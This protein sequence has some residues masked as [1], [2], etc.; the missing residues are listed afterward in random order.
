MIIHGDCL[1]E[2]KKLPDNSIDSAITDPPYCSGGF[3]ETGKKSAP[4]QGIPNDGETFKRLGWFS[5]DNM[6]TMGLIFL[7]R[8]VCVELFRI[9]KP[10]SSALIFCD[11]RMYPHLAPALES[12][13]LQH[14]NLIVWDKGHFG[15]GFGFKPQHELIMEFVKGKPKYHMNNGRNVICSKRVTP[16]KKLHPTQKPVELME[17]LIKVVTPKGGTVLDP[18][19]G[20]GSTL[21]AADKLGMQFIGIEKD[22]QFFKT[23]EHRLAETQISLFS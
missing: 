10:S 5:N 23:S 11:W 12:S 13:G 15:M 18:F 9:L 21:V 22:E 8:S 16:N 2:L 3:T 20:S 6:T 17:E 1:E 7:L 19:A 14:R 4:N